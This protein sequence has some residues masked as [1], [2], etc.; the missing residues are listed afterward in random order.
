MT[1]Q[2]HSW[3]Y[4]K[5]K[6][7]EKAMATH[8]STLAWRI[9][10]TKE[11]GRLQSMALL[12]VGHDWATSLSLSC[13]GEGNGSP[14]QYSCLENPS[15]GGAWWAPIYGVIQSWTWLTWLSSIKD[16]FTGN[17]LVVQWFKLCTSTAGD[18]DWN[19][20]EGTKICMVWPK[21]NNNNFVH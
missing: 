13:I 7:K 8:S 6:K 2:F 11:P 12:R 4:I 16:Q 15:D 5:K 17:S 14:F 18:L 19:P 20:G 10:W 3:V 1:Q 9:P 21:I